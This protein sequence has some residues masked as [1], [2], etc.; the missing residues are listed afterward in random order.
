MESA[1]VESACKESAGAINSRQHRTYS[2]LNACLFLVAEVVLSAEF[3]VHILIF[4]ISY[5]ICVILPLTLT[6]LMMRGLNNAN[7]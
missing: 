3:T 6:S 2:P 5:V 1:S 4:L 7:A